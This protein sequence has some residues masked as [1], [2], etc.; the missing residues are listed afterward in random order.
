MVDEDNLGIDQDGAAVRAGKEI[1]FWASFD[2]RC[3]RRTVTF[4]WS[5]GSGTTTEAPCG[6]SVT[7]SFD[8]AG[9]YTV[10]VEVVGHPNAVG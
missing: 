9:E 2:G 4:A 7:H 10:T 3:L 1:R 5:F 6:R 8:S